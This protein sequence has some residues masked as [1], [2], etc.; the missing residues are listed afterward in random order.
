MT[1]L[2]PGISLKNAYGWRA[3]KLDEDEILARLARLS[4]ERAAAHAS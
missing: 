2:S 3:G 4:Q 1:A